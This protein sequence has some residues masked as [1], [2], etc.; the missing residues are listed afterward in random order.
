[1]FDLWRRGEVPKGFANNIDKSDEMSF[2]NIKKYLGDNED[3]IYRE[4]QIN[5]KNM[6]VV[7]IPAIKVPSNEESRVRSA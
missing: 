7:F 1:M 2:A 6:P 3:V 4:V 5:N